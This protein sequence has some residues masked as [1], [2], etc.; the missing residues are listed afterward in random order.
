M[1]TQ[2]QLDQLK[3]WIETGEEH[4]FYISAAWKAICRVVRRL[5]RNECQICKHKHK[6]YRRGTIVHHIKH[7]KDRPD[8]ALSI[9]DLDT[10]ERQLMLVCKQ[11]H[12]DE[13]PEALRKISRAR[14]PVTVERWD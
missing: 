12:E 11:C 6:R 9:F 3:H 13:H 1:I 4:R 8:L 5:D 10:G 14:E 7:L 2:Q